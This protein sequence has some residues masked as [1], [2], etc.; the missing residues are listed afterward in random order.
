MNC[1]PLLLDSTENSVPYEKGFTLTLAIIT[2]R[3]CLIRRL[4]ITSSTWLDCSILGMLV[5]ILKALPDSFARPGTCFKPFVYK[6]MLKA[7]KMSISAK[8]K[9]KKK[10]RK[11]PNVQRTFLMVYFRGGLLIEGNF[12]FLNGL[13]FTIN[14]TKTAY[15]SLK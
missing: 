11:I 3:L 7:S 6:L 13:S 2:I 9:N 5:P 8:I 1:I 14:T 10:Y 4:L 15:N 12:A